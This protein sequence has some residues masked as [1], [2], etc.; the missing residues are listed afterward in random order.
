M[1]TLE[2][3]S[4][5]QVPGRSYSDLVDAEPAHCAQNLSGAG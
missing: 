1:C 5:G 3:S 2:V 4:P